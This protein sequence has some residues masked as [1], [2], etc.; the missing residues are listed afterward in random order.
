MGKTCNMHERNGES[1]LLAK[2]EEERPL[3][4]EVYWSKFAPV[5]LVGLDNDSNPMKTCPCSKPSLADT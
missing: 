3:G 2:C 4:T 1:S 5:R